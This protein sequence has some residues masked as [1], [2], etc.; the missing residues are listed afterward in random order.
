MHHE[1]LTAEGKKVFPALVKFT[2]F[3]LAGGTALALQL[4]HR[5]SVD[6]DLFSSAPIKKTLLPTVER[7]FSGTL[8][9]TL[10]N[11]R[12]QLTCLVGGVKTTWLHYPFPVLRKLVTLDGQPTL[13]VPELAATK[14]YTIGRRGTFKDYVDLYAVVQGNHIALPD[15]IALAEKKYGDAFNARLFLEQLIYLDDIPDTE[16]TFLIKPVSKH[17]IEKYFKKNVKTVRI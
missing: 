17:E 12:D 1:A 9:R 6:F 4:G 11:N 15:L 13:D 16:I 3:Y 10:V 8:V 2:G 14:A 5:I 7:I